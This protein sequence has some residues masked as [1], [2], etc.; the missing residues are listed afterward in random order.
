M[1]F[2]NKLAKFDDLRKPEATSAN[3][4]AIPHLLFAIDG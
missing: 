2:D 4:Y 3:S 1:R